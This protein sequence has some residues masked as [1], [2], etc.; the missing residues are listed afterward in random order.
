MFFRRMLAG[1]PSCWRLHASLGRMFSQCDS[2]LWQSFCVPH[3]QMEASGLTGPT[4]LCAF[5]TCQFYHDRTFSFP[6]AGARGG[7]PLSE[8]SILHLSL[9]SLG[10]GRLS[11]RFFPQPRTGGSFAKGQGAPSPKGRRLL[12][13]RAGGSFAKGQ[14]AP[15]LL[16]SLELFFIASAS[17]PST[18]RFICVFVFN[19]GGLLGR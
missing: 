10:E 6:E 11:A 18:G 16:R 17:G 1:C 13:R 12:R 3:D 4:R 5:S 15:S 8:A 19:I 7:S 2:V 9:P 14:E